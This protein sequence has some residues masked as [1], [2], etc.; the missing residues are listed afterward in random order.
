[1]SGDFQ[2]TNQTGI[3]EAIRLSALPSAHRLDD[4]LEVRMSSGGAMLAEGRLGSLSKGSGK[5]LVLGPG[6]SA[7][8]STTAVLPP[9][10]GDDIAAALVDV[11]IAFQLGT[12]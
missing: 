3:R 4:A 1:V 2:V 10:P 8:V 11:A 5:P 12:P 6:Q 9:G 7:V